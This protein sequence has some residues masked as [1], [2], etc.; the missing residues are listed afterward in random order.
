MNLTH[1]FGRE[2]GA[3][4]AVATDD[5]PLCL[6]RKSNPVRPTT[7]GPVGVLCSV[8][9]SDQTA[10]ALSATC[11]SPRVPPALYPGVQVAFS[12]G[13]TSSSA[14][15]AWAACTPAVTRSSQLSSTTASA[16][17][18]LSLPSLPPPTI[19]PDLTLPT[20]PAPHS[21]HL[22]V[23]HCFVLLL[24]AGPLTS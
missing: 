15:T 3:G 16:R 12:C 21:L 7:G 17:W 6:L 13:T 14:R 10:N 9:M 24:P 22:V 23:W 11:A 5:A 4:A 20:R 18:V 1:R 8:G 2:G 19:T